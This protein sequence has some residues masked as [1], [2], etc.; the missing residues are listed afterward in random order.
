MKLISR[1]ITN[2]PR[3]WSTKSGKLEIPIVDAEYEDMWKGL[4][5]ELPAGI[6]SVDYGNETRVTDGAKFKDKGDYITATHLDM[7][8]PYHGPQF[9]IPRKPLANDLVDTRVQIQHQ[10]TTNA[11]LRGSFEAELRN[12]DA[13]LERALLES[14]DTVN[15]RPRL[16]NKEG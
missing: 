6:G 3:K 8:T 12:A 14:L 9:S 1:L 13:E 5:S 2:F 16:N 11:N 7:T 10:E 15:G 4:P